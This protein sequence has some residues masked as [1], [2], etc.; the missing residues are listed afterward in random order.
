MKKRLLAWL[1]T[2]A[3]TIGLVP[4][5]AVSAMAALRFCP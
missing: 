5:T 2:A 3:L 1:L 4:V